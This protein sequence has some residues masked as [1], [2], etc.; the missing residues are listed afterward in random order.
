[1][2]EG[3]NRTTWRKP[4]ATSFR[5]A[6]SCICLG[7][8]CPASPP[9]VSLFLL[10]SLF[11]SL[12]HTCMHTN[13]LSPLSIILLFLSLRLCVSQ[14]CLSVSLF[15]AEKK[16]WKRDTGLYENWPHTNP[17]QNYG[18][19]HAFTHLP[20]S[21]VFMHS[22]IFLSPRFSKHDCR[23]C[24]SESTE[25]TLRQNEVREIYG[26]KIKYERKKHSRDPHIY[27]HNVFTCTQRH[28]VQ[29]MYTG[30]DKHTST[31]TNLNTHTP[32]HYHT[33]THAYNFIHTYI[34]RAW[35]Y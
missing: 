29:L 28:Q 33:P 24:A 23:L 12:T 18:G 30:L 26:M 34:F 16:K 5:K 19:P 20:I 35:N 2:K 21:Q 4:L 10:P 11:L 7:Q 25:K 14:F 31:S 3:G 17:L 9:P 32:P 6:S 15:L 22:P 27:I 13:T 1:M 8:L